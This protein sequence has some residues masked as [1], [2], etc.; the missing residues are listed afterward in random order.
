MFL[1]VFLEDKDNYVYKQFNLISS[2]EVGEPK[3]FY[4][5]GSLQRVQEGGYDVVNREGLNLSA[6][7]DK[8]SLFRPNP[9]PCYAYRHEL[10][11]QGDL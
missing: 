3:H 5:Q 8:E 7:A 1:T 4:Y 11:I 10:Q 2:G 9:L 6:V